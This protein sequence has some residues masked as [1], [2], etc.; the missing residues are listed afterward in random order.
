MRRN[1]GSNPHC[2]QPSCSACACVVLASEVRSL[3]QQLAALRRVS[4]PRVEPVAKKWLSNQCTC[5]EEKVDGI[6]ARCDL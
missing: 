6:C 2:S 1:Y 5:G 3:Q 4:E